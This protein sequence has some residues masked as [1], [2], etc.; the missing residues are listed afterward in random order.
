MTVVETD[1]YRVELTGDGTLARLESPAGEYLA[2]L[3]LLAAID[4]THAT[5]ETLSTQTRVVDGA[6]EVERRSTVW[7][8]ARVKLVCG[9]E[10]LEL[11]STV[12][13]RG[14]LT[15][16]RLLAGRSTQPGALTGFLPSG[17]A[18]RSLFSPNPGDPGV[19]VRSAAEPAAIGVAGDGEPGRGQWFFT[20]APLCLA[21]SVDDERWLT[22]A[23]SS[24]LDE[25][26]FTQ[27]VYEPG[28]R[29]F[30]LRLDYE[31][32]T[33]VDGQFSAPTIVIRPG[34]SDPYSGLRRYR[35][36]VGPA[37]RPRPVPEWW[38]APIFC[39]WGA[40]CHLG[41]TSG[42]RPPD[43]STQANYDGFLDHLERHG[44][45]PGTVVVDDKWQEAYG[46][47]V[48]DRDKWPDLKRWVAER[49]SRGQHVLLWWKAWDPEGLP[50]ELCICNHDGAAIAVDPTNP[51]S[52]E[53]VSQIVG[54]LLGL[55]GIDADGLKIDFTGK[56]PSGASLS[57]DGELWGIALLHELLAVVHEAAKRAKPEALLITHTPHPSFVDVTDMVRL[58]DMLRLGDPGPPPPVVPQMRYRADVVRAVCPEL[59]IDTDDWCV[60]DR[61]SWREYLELKPQLGVPSLYYATHLDLSGEALEPEDYAAIRRAWARAQG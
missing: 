40:Q 25:L 2:S 51:E 29:A 36:D 56:T 10:R 15:D 18:F 58:N 1:L 34:F 21:L 17:S 53:A 55:D 37:P 33:R 50:A 13:G 16:A 41:W 42:K 24:E 44:V 35:E 30:N 32:H 61:A 22:L 14:V 47:C 60:P 11:H 49:R 12:T 52:R 7:D 3:R 39:G 48:P 38:T 54:G 19:I 31:S 23:I 8:H 45:V 20:P 4:T 46:T 57:A 9:E 6:I 27:L 26:T 59:L 5:D 28:D 43:L